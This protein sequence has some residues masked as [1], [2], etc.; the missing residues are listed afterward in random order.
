MSSDLPAFAVQVACDLGAEFA[1]ARLH[2]NRETACLLRD[3][4]PEPAA[5]ISS[6]GLGVRIL[7]KG[8]LSFAATNDLS[9]DSIRILC[10]DAVRAAEASSVILNKRIEF[11]EQKGVK[12]SWR[13]E[14]RK[15]IENASVEDLMRILWELDKTL[16]H[17]YDGI[18]FTNRLLTISTMLE[19]KTY[20]NSD[21]AQIE[22][23]VPRIQ[24]S[25]YLTTPFEGKTF[26]VTIPPGYSQLGGSGGWE[27][28]E[29]LNLQEYVPQEAKIL[30]AVIKNTSKPPAGVV[31]VV[32]GPEVAGIVAHESAGHPGEADRIQGREAAQAG[33]SYLKP[34]DLG[35]RIGSDQ[36]FVSDDPTIGGSMGFYLYD[37]EGVPARKRKLIEAGVVSEFLQNRAT[38]REFGLDSSNSASR[39]VAFDREPIIRMAN[40]FVEPGDYSFEELLEDVKIG[41]YIKS[42][43]EWNI[44][45]RRFNERYVGLEAYLIEDGQLKGLIRDPILEITTIKFWSSLDARGRDLTFNAAMCGK[46][47]P[48][49]AA[50]V[51]TG[52]PHIRLRG[53][54]IGA[55]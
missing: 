6:R 53:V 17:D 33:E 8:A 24:Y 38:A 19:M 45:D 46:G 54:G 25:S 39:S 9:R 30:A 40:T 32:L 35:L 37:D 29:R 12:T 23:R 10:K 43:M 36:A 42:F 51:W 13:A 4:E 7:C 34:T 14:E 11:C 16:R 21:G 20:V 5:I 44:D 49:Q 28:V 47:D 18:T 27:T 15:N 48:M 31:D 55:R 26:T 1:E 2:E 50:P 3:G 22:S 41:V 52:G